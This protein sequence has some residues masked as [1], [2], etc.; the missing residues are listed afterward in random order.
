MSVKDFKAMNET[1]ALCTP[2]REHLDWPFVGHEHRLLAA[3]LDTFIS[4]G[5]LG[6]IDHGDADGACKALVK[7]LGVA[8]F[9]RH[10]VPKHCGGAT[11][12]LDSRALCVIRETLAYADGL[13][14]FVFAMQGLG[15]GAISLSGS[16]QLKHRILPKVASGELISA[17]A[18]TEPNAGSDVAA[19]STTARRDGSDYIIDGEKLWISNGGIAD[20]Y[21]LFARTGE[22]P[23]TR[24]ISAFVVFADTPGLVIAERIETI[25][26]HPLARIRFEQCRIPASQL[27]GAPGEGFKIAMRTLDI[28]RPSVA[29]AAIGFARRALDEAVAHARTRRMFGATLADLPTAQS[30]L[31][32]M[33]TAIDSATLL[34]LRTAWRR[35]VQKRPITREAAMAKMTATENAQWVIDQALQ[36]FGGR[37]VRVGEITER[38]YRE[39][40]ALRIYEGATEVQRLVIGRELMKNTALA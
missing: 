18:L 24:G 5:G 6:V 27:L 19:M 21:T 28:F 1:T 32:D 20:V 22:A 30:T 33:A 14:D 8:G 37:G 25:A 15:T 35:D 38:L 26:P 31:G 12:E 17:F 9:L 11:P 7:R 36:M 13:A 2:S 23:G 4:G 34:T 3:A 39:I 40:R 29:A 10:C 16:D